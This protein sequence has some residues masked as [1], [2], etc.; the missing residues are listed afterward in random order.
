MTHICS[1]CSYFSV[2]TGIRTRQ[3]LWL[4]RVIAPGLGQFEVSAQWS[5]IHPEREILLPGSWAK[6]ITSL[7]LSVIEWSVSK[8]NTLTLPLLCSI[9]KPYLPLPSP[10]PPHCFL[11]IDTSFLYL[12]NIFSQMFLWLGK[13]LIKVFTAQL[14]LLVFCFNSL[15]FWAVLLFLILNSQEIPNHY[16]PSTYSGKRQTSPFKNSFKN[17]QGGQKVQIFSYT[18]NQAWHDDYT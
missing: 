4:E 2:S 7:E 12:M 3:V 14:L 1:P 9:A 13:T 10:Q 15:S 5:G 8:F 16:P 18:I 17:F 6:T 11:M